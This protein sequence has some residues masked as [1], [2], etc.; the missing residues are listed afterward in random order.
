[1]RCCRFVPVATLPQQ[2]AGPDFLN[3]ILSANIGEDSI[4]LIAVRRVVYLTLSFLLPL[5]L[6]SF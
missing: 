4:S 2:I 6:S 1:M 5:F 3:I